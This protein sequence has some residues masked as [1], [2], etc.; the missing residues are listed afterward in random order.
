M[1][2]ALLNFEKSPR[3]SFLGKRSTGLQ[4][5][6]G[7]GLLAVVLVYAVDLLF[8]AWQTSANIKVL[9]EKIQTLQAAP[10][11]TPSS[12]PRLA[13]LAGAQVSVKNTGLFANLSKDQKRNLNA[14]VRQLNIPWYDIFEQLEKS[15]PQDVA[16]L[17][18][19]P[20]G[21]RATIKIQ[22]E[23]KSLD[24]LLA[25]ASALQQQG[26]FGRLS[27]SKHET[28][29]QD[30]NKPIRLIFELELKAPPRLVQLALEDSLMEP[31]ESVTPTSTT[32]EKKGI[33]TLGEK[34]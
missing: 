14:V 4:I 5:F 18:M 24:S 6:L 11:V 25:Y 3:Y 17:G 12:K 27:Y 23:S 1:K 22:A 10:A 15:T 34:Q 26:I 28:N 30:P 32:S 9:Q 8:T 33:K 21:Q 16:L 29:D 7:V 31:K 2:Q 13:S 19:E 20:D